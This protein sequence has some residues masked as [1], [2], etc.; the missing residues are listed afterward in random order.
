MITNEDAGVPCAAQ[1]LRIVSGF[2]PID[3]PQGG[4]FTCPT[5]SGGTR[6]ATVLVA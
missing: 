1:P 3:E 2:E 4:L 5:H 6:M